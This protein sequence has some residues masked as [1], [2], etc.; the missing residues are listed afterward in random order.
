MKFTWASTSQVGPRAAN[1][2]VVSIWALGD[3]SCAG[4]VAD[5][6]G[7]YNGGARASA[8]AATMFENAV[9]ADADLDLRALALD[10]HAEIHRLQ[11][12]DPNYRGMATTLS[13]VVVSEN[14]LK[15]VH[16][17]DTRVMLQRNNGIRR[18][19][20]DHSEAQRLFRDGLLTREQFLAYPR[21]NVLE[22][23]LGIKD[24]PKIDIGHHSVLSGDRIYI[25][26]DGAHRKVLLSELRDISISSREPTDAVRA[27]LETI[28][29]RIPDDNYSI[30]VIFAD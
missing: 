12:L 30:A 9:N 5:G 13:G 6:V 28:E 22:S 25:T 21:K 10:V 4:L 27:I 16:C 23:A 29:P 26:S 19:T 8:I 3:S 2:D 18:L 15:F 1:E 24:T 14:E 7:G 11:Q 17:G 20:V